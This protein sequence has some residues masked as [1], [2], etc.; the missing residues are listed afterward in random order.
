M[1]EVKVTG[2]KFALFTFGGFKENSK[3]SSAETDIIT[4]ALELC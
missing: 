1:R 3:S 2:P 4:M